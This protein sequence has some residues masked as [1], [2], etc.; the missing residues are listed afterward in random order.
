MN[1]DNQKDDW[2]ELYTFLQQLKSQYGIQHP[3]K[4]LKHIGCN[5]WLKH[6]CYLPSN[7]PSYT[8]DEL[9]LRTTLRN[10]KNGTLIIP[11]P[12]PIYKKINDFCSKHP[13][14]TLRYSE[15]TNT[16][17]VSSNPPVHNPKAFLSAFDWDFTTDPENIT[18][19]GT[20]ELELH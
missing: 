14:I 6:F 10:L 1:T 11:P 12:H 7:I 16:L 18:Y 13:E 5:P 20:I 4:F 3:A 2:P 9:H 8:G 15:S 17:H 19:C